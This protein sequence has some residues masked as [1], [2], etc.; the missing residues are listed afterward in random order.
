M[1]TIPADLLEAIADE[2]PDYASLKAFSL[3]GSSFRA[4]SQRILLRTKKLKIPAV[5]A[6]KILDFLEES[7]HVAGYVRALELTLLP[8]LAALPSLTYTEEVLGKFKNMAHLT[9]I[10]PYRCRWVDGSGM[11]LIILDFIRRQTLQ[12]LHLSSFDQL[13][14]NLFPFFLSSAPTVTLL[15]VSAETDSSRL[16]DDVTIP[17]LSKVESLALYYTAD[18]GEVLLSP[19]CSPHLQNL[20]RFWGPLGFQ[21][22]RDIIGASSNT[23]Q[24]ICFDGIDI[25]ISPPISPFPLPDL[26]SLRFLKVVIR[27][28]ERDTQ[29]LVE[30]I[31]SM[32][33]VAVES[34]YVLFLARYASFVLSD[35]TMDTLNEA[36]RGRVHLPWLRW[37]IYYKAEGDEL[38]DNFR[39]AVERGIP[40]AH[41]VG[42]LS[43]ERVSSGEISYWP[44]GIL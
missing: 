29:W 32:L 31:C 36:L 28:G 40:R 37:G 30:M 24:E 34:V 41:S 43:V 4:P 2:I 33:K 27:P 8:T 3:T 42:R 12:S 11:S 18:L 21:F 25:G 20:R 9:I 44:S 10:N 22:T 13:P 15:K 38:L 35:R 14:A 23:L 19:R 7:P 6:E 17:V 5:S 16:G 26:P 39:A 1:D